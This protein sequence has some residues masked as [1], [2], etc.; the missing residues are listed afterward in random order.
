MKNHK[1]LTIFITLCLASALF[2]GVSAQTSTSNNTKTFFSKVYPGILIMLNATGE[3]VPDGNIT[4]YLMVEC[5]A[6]DVEMEHLNITIY[7]FI[8]GK[9]KIIL[10][11]YTCTEKRTPLGFK[12][13]YIYNITVHVPDRVWDATYV[14]LYLSYVLAG[15]PFEDNPSFPITIVRNVYLEELEKLFRSLNE[16]YTLINQTFWE[17]FNMSLT[18]ESLSLLNKT[19]RELEQN[20]TILQGSLNELGSTRMAVAVLAV[21]TVFFV[22]TTIYLFIRKPRE[23]W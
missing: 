14:E 23:Y 10:G 22:A 15:Q 5:R 8:E 12:E 6:L 1:T 20:Y 17:T 11:N 4:L 18:P 19:Y 7:G 3:T 9:E 16:S 21:T 2:R 13:T